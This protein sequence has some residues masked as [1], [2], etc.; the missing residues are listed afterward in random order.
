MGVEMAFRGS[1]RRCSKGFGDAPQS[2]DRHG[3]E[4]SEELDQ[5]R[6]E[7]WLQ[8]SPCR[9][10][11]ERAIDYQQPSGECLHLRI[12]HHQARGYRHQGLGRV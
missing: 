5:Q 8:D 12:L 10:R 2:R 9:Y 3:G 11:P 4:Y 6:I 7:Q 1:R